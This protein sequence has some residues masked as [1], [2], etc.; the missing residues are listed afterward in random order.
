MT[1]VYWRVDGSFVTGRRRA[2]GRKDGWADDE[3]EK[4]ERRRTEKMMIREDAI[5]RDE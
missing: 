4:M 5:V 1:V 3:S 2:L